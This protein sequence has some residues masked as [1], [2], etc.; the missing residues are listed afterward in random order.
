MRWSQNTHFDGTAKRF[1]TSPVVVDTSRQGT[2]MQLSN[3]SAINLRISDECLL[4]CCQVTSIMSGS[5]DAGGS[6][7]LG[8]EANVE[9]SA[10]DL[11]SF[12]AR[13]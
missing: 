12:S 9:L 5:G 11:D 3:N 7:G 6:T 2:Y 1:S 10:P 13:S 8:D 4:G